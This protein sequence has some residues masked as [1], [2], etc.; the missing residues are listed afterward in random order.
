MGTR[1]QAE[2][3]AV[4]V[5]IGFALFTG[6]VLAGLCFLAVAGGSHLAGVPD[7]R[8]WLL[9]AM[10]SSGAVFVT[11]VLCVLLPKRRAGPSSAQPSQ[12]GRTRPDS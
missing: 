9:F 11:G 5:E 7:P 10:L 4:T 8:P 2:R 12:P 1:T 6:T 3:D